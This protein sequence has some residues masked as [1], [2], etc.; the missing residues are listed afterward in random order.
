MVDIIVAK[1]ELCH[2]ARAHHFE[3]QLDAR[4]IELVVG[5]LR[6]DLVDRERPIAT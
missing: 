5:A 2:L 6:G 3:Q 4:Q 1:V